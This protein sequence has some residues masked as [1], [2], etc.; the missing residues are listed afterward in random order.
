MH[1]SSIQLSSVYCLLPGWNHSPFLLGP[2]HQRPYVVWLLR[3]TATEWRPRQRTTS[4]STS[5]DE[6]PASCGFLPKSML[7]ALGWLRSISLEKGSR[8]TVKPRART[9]SQMTSRLCTSRPPTAWYSSL[10]PY[11][12]T[13][14][15]RKRSP[16]ALTTWRPRT[17][18]GNWL[19]HRGS[20]PPPGSTASASPQRSTKVRSLRPEQQPPREARGW[21]TGEAGHTRRARRRA[22]H[23]LHR[24]PARASGPGA[25]SR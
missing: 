10:A 4:S 25:K 15:N 9:V 16:W 18:S 17:D 24:M 21:R 12:L 2:P 13:P 5:R 3:I 20:R 8:T 7:P 1:Q 6:S 19:S 11:Q 14:R 22:Q 23:A